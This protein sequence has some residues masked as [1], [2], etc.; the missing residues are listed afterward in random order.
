[1]GEGGQE[2]GAH[3]TPQNTQSN[4]LSYPHPSQFRGPRQNSPVPLRWGSWG[5]LCA[6]GEAGWGKGAFFSPHGGLIWPRAPCRAPVHGSFTA[7]EKQF[8]SDLR[9]PVKFAK[10]N[11]Q[12]MRRS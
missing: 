3:S 4:C 6:G 10:S 5:T 7:R 8:C 2:L 9:S 11:F 12:L 1:M